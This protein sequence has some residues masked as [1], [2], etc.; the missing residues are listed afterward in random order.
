MMIGRRQEENND[1]MWGNRS[2]QMIVREGPEWREIEVAINF[3]ERRGNSVASRRMLRKNR[4]WSTENAAARR[5]IVQI[6]AGKLS[7]LANLD[8]RICN[9][10]E[11]WSARD[12][13]RDKY[14]MG[15]GTRSKRAR[16]RHSVSPVA[17]WLWP[18]MSDENQNAAICFYIVRNA[19]M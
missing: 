14:Q 17:H 1:A 16:W 7:I 8:E 13:E 9:S 4:K 12:F 18:T 3:V 10:Y 6:F 11:L 5:N 15:W 19:S 2:T